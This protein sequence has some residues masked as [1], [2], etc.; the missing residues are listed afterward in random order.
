[1][2]F[3]EQTF[4]SSYSPHDRYTHADVHDIKFFESPGGW[5]MWIASDGGLYY[6][7][8]EGDHT[9]PRMYGIH[10]TDFWGF[11]AG[12]QDGDVMLG[13]TYH[14]GTLIKYKDIYKYGATDENSGGW[15]AEG[16]GDNVRGFVNY[17]NNKVA[18]DDGGSFEFSEDRLIRPAN[19]SFD[20]NTITKRHSSTAFNLLDVP[21]SILLNKLHQ[22]GT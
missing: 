16:A 7:S 1:M 17:G 10:G 21:M 4:E 13:G 2:E 19:L 20:G 5:D 12:Y 18:Y 3:M 9:E 6:S 22:M 14:N 11:Q 8:D 15:M